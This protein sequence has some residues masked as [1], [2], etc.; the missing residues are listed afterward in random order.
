MLP[1]RANRTGTENPKEENNHKEDEHHEK[2]QKCNEQECDIWHGGRLARKEAQEREGAYRYQHE[3]DGQDPQEPDDSEL[4]AIDKKVCPQ[5]EIG[6][7][8]YSPVD[9]DRIARDEEREDET[10]AGEE[11]DLAPWDCSQFI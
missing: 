9:P 5:G 11:S 7:W 6:S 4:N 10:E 1:V 3:N 2:E 8:F